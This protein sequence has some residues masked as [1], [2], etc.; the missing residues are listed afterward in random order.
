MDVSSTFVATVTPPPFQKGAEEARHDSKVREIVPATNQSSNSAKNGKVADE[1]GNTEGQNSFLQ[2]V[3]TLADSNIAVHQKNGEQKDKRDQ[4]TDKENK[5]KKGSNKNVYINTDSKLFISPSY[6]SRRFNARIE[7]NENV[8]QDNKFSL[9][10]K[11]SNAIA[12]K[13]AS[14]LPF[15]DRGKI[16]TLQI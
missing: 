11:I 1:R 2:N 12:K 14:I 10:F 8:E 15:Y 16:I 7:N 6:A 13:Y 3:G 5:E 9:Y 4:Q